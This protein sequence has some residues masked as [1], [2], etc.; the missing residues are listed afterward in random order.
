MEFCHEGYDYYGA[1][2]K[3]GFPQYRFLFNRW[4]IQTNKKRFYV[5]NGGLSLR[6]IASTLD[7]LARKE[8]HI[9]KT[10]FMEDAFLAIGGP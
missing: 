6:K 9:S 2:W 3:V 7:L 4:A 8:A 10:F 5:G 1:P